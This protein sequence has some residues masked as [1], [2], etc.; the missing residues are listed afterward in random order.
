MV[1]DGRLR[2]ARQ[3]ALPDDGRDLRL[4]DP[5]A[6]ARQAARRLR[7]RL[8]QRAARRRRAEGAGRRVRGARR[9]RPRSGSPPST[10]RRSARSARA[11]SS[12]STRSAAS[13]TRTSRRSRR[14]P[15][16]TRSTTRCSGGSPRPRREVG[17]DDAGALARAA[18]RGRDRRVR[19]VARAP[20]AGLGSGSRRSSSV[21]AAVRIALARRMPRAVDHGRRAHLLGAREVVRARRAASSSAACRRTRLR[22]RLPGAD[23]AGVRGS[24]RRCPTAYARGEGD[25]RGRDVARR[26]PGVLPRAPAAHAGARARRGRARRARSRRC[27]TRAR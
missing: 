7:R 11:T 13:P 21:S 14:P 4:G 6:L 3:P 19:A 15:A 8:V 2:R 9:S 5:R 25:Q 23:R 20:R 1:A 27:S 16:A 24:S 17:I 12:A 10:A 18:R 22:L 26:D